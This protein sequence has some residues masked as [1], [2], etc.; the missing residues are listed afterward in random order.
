MG[1]DKNTQFH[2]VTEYKLKLQTNLKW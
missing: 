1:T 2:L